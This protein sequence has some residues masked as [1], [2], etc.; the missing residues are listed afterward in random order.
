MI[1]L[2]VVHFCGP[3]VILSIRTETRKSLCFFKRISFV[4]YILLSIVKDLLAISCRSILK[5]KKTRKMIAIWCFILFFILHC[6][7]VWNVM[8]HF[9]HSPTPQDAHHVLSLI[10]QITHTFFLPRNQVH[11]FSLIM[12]YEV[13]KNYIYIC[14]KVQEKQDIQKRNRIN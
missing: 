4:V 5:L 12:L 3:S 6:L 13:Q 8:K 7:V 11:S 14:I 2:S 9:T 1:L 10:L